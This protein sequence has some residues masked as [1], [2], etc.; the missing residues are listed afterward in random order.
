M[1]PAAKKN[2]AQ[3]QKD[4]ELQQAKMKQFLMN[5]NKSRRQVKAP[6]EQR[7]VLGVLGHK[8]LTDNEN[9]RGLF[10]TTEKDTSGRGFGM[11][12][13]I[14]DLKPNFEKA[15]NK[16]LEKEKALDRA[17]R[18]GE[19]TYQ[20]L[21]REREEKEALAGIAP[22]SPIKYDKVRETTDKRIAAA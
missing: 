13:I 20:R 7:W 3:A 14:P 5:K 18:V 6:K 8:P 1:N 11:E 15:Q 19:E 21:K 10:S 12:E 22:P 16:Y 2:A 4:R 9:A 17:L